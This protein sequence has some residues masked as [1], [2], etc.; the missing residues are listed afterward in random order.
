MGLPRAFDEHRARRNVAKSIILKKYDFGEA[1]ELVVFLS[2]ELGWLR[3]IA[4][5]AKKSRVRFGGHLEP[6][7]LVDFVLRPRKKDDLVWIDESQVIQGF[8]RIRSDIGKV[9]RAQYFLELCSVFLAEDHPDPVLFDFILTF[10]ENLETGV[11]N[12][13]R[14][15]LEEIR[16]LGI[17]GYAP[18]FDL[19]PA[20]GKPLGRGQEAVFV[21]ALG[22]ACHRECVSGKETG[23]SLLSPNTLAIVRRGLEVG[24][25]AAGRLR[26]N[27]SGLQELREAL[28]A[29]VRY[30]RGAEINSLRFL[31][32]IEAQDGKERRAMPGET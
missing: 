28:S 15:L 21:A 2:C 18:R 5:N 11:P 10:L 3:G 13:V 14:L 9:A 25:E 1:D 31:E 22:G 4:K 16:L 8:L 29:F 19:C 20:C 23:N 32:G 7:S 17:L 26:L 30:Q 6:L 12:P 27:R 24:N